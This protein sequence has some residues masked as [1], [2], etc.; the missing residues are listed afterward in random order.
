MNTWRDDGINGIRGPGRRLSEVV[1]F[2]QQKFLHE[3]A[4]LLIREGDADERTLERIVHARV[5]VGV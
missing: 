1:R 5:P 4:D 3:L 2:S